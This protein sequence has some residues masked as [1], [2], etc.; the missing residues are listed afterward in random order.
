MECVRQ[1]LFMPRKSLFAQGVSYLLTLDR[2]SFH[3]MLG[4]S[5]RDVQCTLDGITIRTGSYLAPLRSQRYSETLNRER[6]PYSAV[7]SKVFS[8]LSHFL[9][10]F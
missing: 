6:E 9:N 8:S 7:A 4:F 3:V 5:P 10:L 2:T 1:F